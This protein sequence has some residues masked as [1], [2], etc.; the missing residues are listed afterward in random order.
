MRIPSD[1]GLN[2][3]VLNGLGSFAITVSRS[4]WPALMVTLDATEIVGG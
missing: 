1:I 3:S 2:V 4:V